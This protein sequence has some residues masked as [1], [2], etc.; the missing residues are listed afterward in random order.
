MTYA[1][2]KFVKTYYGVTGSD[3]ALYPSLGG[4]P[5]EAGG[6]VTGV[7]IPFG[8]SFILSKQWLASV[9]GRYEALQ[10]DAKDS[11]IVKERGD[12]NQWIYGAGVSYLF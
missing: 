9:G 8:L 2:D 3:I 5:F 6:G 7:N 4:K 11:P 12:K 10:G 1:N